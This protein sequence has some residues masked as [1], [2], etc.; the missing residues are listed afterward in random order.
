[1]TL[2]TLEHDMKKLNNKKDAVE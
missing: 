2:E 1:M